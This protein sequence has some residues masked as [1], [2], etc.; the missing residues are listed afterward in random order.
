MSTAGHQFQKRWTQAIGFTGSQLR[1][2]FRF[3]EA[4]YHFSTFDEGLIKSAM[5]QISEELGGCIEF[6]D[7][8]S[9][10]LYHDKYIQIRHK[11]NA[12]EYEGCGSAMGMVTEGWGISNS[13]GGKYQEIGLGPGCLPHPNII[14]HELYHALG[15]A[16]EM[17]RN[18]RDE[19]IVVHWENM[20]AGAAQWF[21]TMG[22]RWMDIGQKYEIDSIMHYGGIIDAENGVYSMTRVDNGK[23]VE[24]TATRVSSIDIIQLHTM[25][26]NFCPVRPETLLC[27]NGDYFL[28]SRSCDGVHDCLDMSDEGRKYCGAHHCGETITL[29]SELNKDFE[30]TFHLLESYVDGMVAYGTDRHMLSYNSALT[31]WTI[32]EISNSAT[33]AWGLNYDGTCPQ[34]AD[35]SWHIEPKSRYTGFRMESGI[36]KF[37]FT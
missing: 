26:L 20:E 32:T 21:M 11:N 4:P 37:Y 3:I 29:S 15:F 9:T 22:D 1:I 10:K 35:D 30:G 7:D 17:N 33:L 28:K 23:P 31:A 2:P 16:H 27:D 36:N 19:N 6:Y 14:Q 18:D 12:G 24:P 25:Y 5:S 13:E 34:G 8:T